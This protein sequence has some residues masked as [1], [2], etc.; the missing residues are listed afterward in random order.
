MARRLAVL[1]VA[2]V[3]VACGNTSS[4]SAS[5]GSSTS[6]PGVPTATAAPTGAPTDVP[7]AT[8]EPTSPESLAPTV[9][10]GGTWVLP[11]AG[12]KITQYTARLSAR[13]SVPPESTVTKV[14]FRVAWSGGKKVA[15]TATETTV[16][17]N[18]ACTVNLLERRVPP[19]KI[20]FTFDVN[21]PTGRI[22]AAPGGKRSATY[23]VPPPKPTGVK[24]SRVSQTTNA[25]GSTALVERLSWREPAGYATEFRI[26]GVTKCLNESAKNN[27]KPCLVQDTPLPSSALAKRKTV[28]GSKRSA[29][30]R[31]TIPE[32][33]CGGTLWC[34]D[35]YAIVLGAVNDYGRS[36][37][38]IARS[39]DVCW[40]CT[41]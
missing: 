16:K 3:L 14:V 5:P 25:D 17:G 2:I 38:A 12:A 22:A 35:D 1:L 13:L 7:V 32:G 37:F 33:E 11:Q 40:Q 15:C 18:W 29:T 34:S 39:A 36:V 26:Y 9:E 6:A 30:L 19:G 41:Y 27:G 8:P 31:Y 21:D 20:A 4:P 10:I 24:L 23:A 28:D